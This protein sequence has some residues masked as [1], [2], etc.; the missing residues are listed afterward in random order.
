[1]GEHIGFVSTRFAGTDG[2]TLESAKWARVFYEDQQHLNFWY[3]GRMDRD[4][5]ESFCVPEAYFG[6]PEVEWINSQVWGTTTRN[7][8]VTRRIWDLALYLKY[9][10]YEFINHYDISLLILENVVS[11]PM[12]IPL[13]VAVTELLSETRM[14]A[15]GH[16]HDFYWERTRFLVNSVNDYLEMSFPPREVDLQHAVINQSAQ[17]ELSWRKGVPSTLVPNVFDFENPAPG[18]DEY[19]SD[20][21]AEIGLGP[22]D[23]MILQPTRVVPRKGIEHAIQLVKM[24]GDPKYKLVISHEAGDEGFEYRSMLNETAH[25]E[26]V[27]LRFIETRIGDKRKIDRRGKKIYTLWDL[28]P[29][30]D[31]VTYTSLYEGF[32]NALLEAFYFKKP[33]FV[34]RYS[35]FVRDIEPK[36]FRAP[37]MEGYVTHKAV[38]EVRRILE[39]SEYRQEMV[40][41]NYNLAAKFYSFSVLRRKLYSLIANIIGTRS[42]A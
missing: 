41:Y 21:R 20:I 8:A 32:G 7:P 27:D 30:A 17:E 19:S 31:L 5:E 29:H 13:G 12:H 38:Q 40:D 34:N 39:D 25:R 14:P 11:I 6:H 10:L 4:P 9:T 35:I 42:P 3:A 2:V 36:G 37:I 23:V 28:Y 22:D 18:L 15:I 16:H 24:L 1:M 26:G 33:V